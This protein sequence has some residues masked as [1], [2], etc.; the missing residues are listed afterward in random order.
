MTCTTCRKIVFSNE[1]GMC[2]PCQS[3]FRG[4]PM[5]DDYDYS[6]LYASKEAAEIKEQID[7]RNEQIEKL[8]R[9]IEAKEEAEAQT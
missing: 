9:R 5:P 7:E 4:S 3:G 2:H 1:T 6:T 8:N